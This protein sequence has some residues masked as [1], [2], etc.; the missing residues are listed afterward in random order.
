LSLIAVFVLSSCGRGPDDS[1]LSGATYV[2][3]GDSYTAAPYVPKTESAAGCIRSDHN[4]PHLLAKALKVTTLIDR[5][6]GGATTQNLVTPQVTLTGS[7]VEPQDNQLTNDTDLVTV[8][9]GGNDSGIAGTLF[10]YC[11]AGT[12]CNTATVASNAANALKGLELAVV[13]GLKGIRSRAPNAR[14]V[15]VGYPQIA[16]STGTCPL[17]PPLATTD[18]ALFNKINLGLNSALEKAAKATAV[19]FVDVYGPSK[20]HDICSS[21]PWVNGTVENLTKAAALHPFGREQEAVAKLIEKAL[22]R[23]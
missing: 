22:S 17:L 1:K 20:G 8:G 19:T 18:L 12:S 11:A 23:S 15:L 9:I 21:D 2:A 13:N 14:I 5:S 3:I 7:T 6:C 10:Y 4:Y 16:P